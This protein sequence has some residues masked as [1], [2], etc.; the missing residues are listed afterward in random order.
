MLPLIT[1]YLLQN[2]YTFVINDFEENFLSHPN[3]PS[4]YAITDTFDF[5]GIENVA[6]KIPDEQFEALPN[7]FLSFVQNAQNQSE[8][9]LVT[10][11]VTTVTIEFE[12]EKNTIPTAEFLERWNGIIVAIEANEMPSQEKAVANNSTV[13]Y[14]L[15]FLAITLLIGYQNELTV[16]NALFYFLSTLGLLLSIF[17]I[18]E[19][20]GAETALIS[21]LCNTSK[22]T[23]CDAVITS[24]NG[25]INSWLSIA[26]LPIL[27]FS[28]NGI[29]LLVNFNTVPVIGAFSFLS[30]PLLCYFVWVQ[31]TKIKKWCVLCLGVSFVMLLQGIL[32][33]AFIGF[34]TISL[35]SISYYATA[36]I[37]SST[38]WW[39]INPILNTN[40]SLKEENRQFKKFKRNYAVF[41]SLE[42]P[43]ADS[44]TFHTLQGINI[45]H[46]DAPLQLHLML[47]PSCGHCHTAYQKAIAL[48][49][50]FPDKVRLR[51]LFNIN[52]DNKDNPYSSIVKQLLTLNTTDTAKAKEALSDWHSK[53]LSL[54]EWKRKWEISNVLTTIE[55]EI[56]KQYDWCQ[57]NELNYTPITIINHKLFPN[58]Y[59][60]EEVKY[61]IT[62]IIENNQ[63]NDTT[64]FLQE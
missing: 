43:I 9:V 29:A 24:T 13:R 26:D 61:F 56:R 49:K 60:L 33:L 14:F 45:G 30:I 35:Y 32:W 5:L 34:T 47:S 55:A 38:I 36:V 25:K 18:Q 20:L 40:K 11:T 63:T 41:Q 42:K 48:L 21:K 2:K 39:L 6:A 16:L 57:L 15:P 53:N 23:S 22:N 46:P 19:K 7:Q 50:N 37:L 3:Y 28:S 10:K 31:Q 51:I 44:D 12:K 8:L 52:I 54:E 58:E 64:I 1:K 17:I 27:F 62:D 59:N 4:L